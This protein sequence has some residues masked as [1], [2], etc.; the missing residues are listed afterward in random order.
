MKF[1]FKTNK[2]TGKYRSFYPDSC[3][4]KLEGKVVGSIYHAD[5]VRIQLM[6][7]KNDITEDKNRNC[8]WKNIFLAKT[9]NDLN[10]AKNF[11]NEH[12]EQIMLKYKLHKLED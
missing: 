5:K 11:L 1:T 3:D 7:V 12:I 4:I 10:E 2:S 9:F 8:I 6:V